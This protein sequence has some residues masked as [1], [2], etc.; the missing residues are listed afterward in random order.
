MSSGKV[1]TWDCSLFLGQVTCSNNKIKSVSFLFFFFFLLFF[2][3]SSF[4]PFYLYFFPSLF[5]SFLLPFFLC[6]RNILL[7]RYSWILTRSFS[8]GLYFYGTEG[9]IREHENIV[10]FYFVCLSVCLCVRLKKEGEGFFW[11]GESC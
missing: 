2:H 5:L 8:F 4:L 6:C 10:S 11:T 9:R 1:L 7:S 3:F